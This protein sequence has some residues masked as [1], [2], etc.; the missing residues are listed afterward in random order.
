VV[1][2]PPTEVAESAAFCEFDEDEVRVGTHDEMDKTWNQLFRWKDIER[3]CFT[4][5]GLYSS[6]RIFVELKCGMRP[7]VLLT[8]ARG[9]NELFGALTERGYFQMR[10]GAKAMGKTGGSTYC[11]PPRPSSG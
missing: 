4:D 7:V 2:V 11:W 6:D 5:E 3:V 10:Y 8:E 9:G 1:E